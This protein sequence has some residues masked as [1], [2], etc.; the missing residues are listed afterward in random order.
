VHTL[1]QQGVDFIK[2]QS[3]L[4][5]EAYFAIAAAAKRE[6]IAF[7][8]HV[9]DRVTAVEASEAGQKSIEHLTGVLRACAKDEP[10]LM[11]EQRQNGVRKETEAQS[12]GRELAWEKELLQT[13]SAQKAG[14]LFEKFAQNQTGQV[15]TLVLLQRL[16]F[17]T[18]HSMEFDGDLRAKYVP[19]SLRAKWQAAADERSKTMRGSEEA[20]NQALLRKSMQVVSRMRAAGVLVLPGTDTGA[21]VLFPGFA[22]HDELLLLVRAGLTPM[23]A[24]QAAT[25]AAAEFLDKG[26]EQGTVAAGKFADLVLLDANPLDDISNTGKIRAVVLRGKFLDRIAL[27]DIL[28]S[29]EKFAATN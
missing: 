13:Y 20:L 15:P 25:K 24:L 14:E 21:P 23:Q 28:S 6:R 11:R 1:V 27:N 4:D 17:A 2:V 16:A 9:P 8:G 7:V 22:L 3:V 12:H 19:H 5:R 18:R 10:R 26:G 29:V